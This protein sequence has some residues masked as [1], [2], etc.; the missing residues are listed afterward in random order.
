MDK[1]ASFE[2]TVD[3]F[4]CLEREG[5]SVKIYIPPPTLQGE[6]VVIKVE[7]RDHMDNHMGL[8]GEEGCEL[9]ADDA[10]RHSADVHSLTDRC[11]LWQMR[12]TH[13]YMNVKVNFKRLHAPV[14]CPTFL[15]V[16]EMIM[17]GASG[18]ESGLLH[19]TT[20]GK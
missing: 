11:S 7:R 20:R 3:Y 10:N 9:D 8:N 4:P 1:L 12:A 5:Y 14:P 16:S 6:L 17:S 15:C 18:E 19:P 2:A 13:E